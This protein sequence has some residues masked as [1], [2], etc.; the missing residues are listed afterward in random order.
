MSVAFWS[1]LLGILLITM[2]LAGTILARLLLSSAMVYMVVGFAFGPLGLDIVQLDPKQHV[3]VL[4]WGAEL[5]LLISLFAVGLNMG[6]VPLLDKRWRLPLLLAFV[7]MALTVGLVSM[8]GIYLLDLPLGA[9]VLLGGILAPTDPVLASGVQTTL[10]N[11]HDRLRFSLSGE[12]GLN[13]GTAFPFVMLGLGLLGLHDLGVGG[14]RWWLVDLIWATFGGLLIGA[15]S[16]ASIGKLVVYLRT[17]HH[18]AVGRDEFLSLGLI[19][20]AYGAAQLCL[21]SGFLAVFAAGLA[22]QRVKEQPRAGSQS[23]GAASS[24]GGH[25]EG[26]LATHPHHA[27]AAMSHAVQGFNDRLENLAELALVL[28]I[29]VMLA[30]TRPS[31]EVFGLIALLFVPLRAIAVVLGTLGEPLVGHQRNMICWFGIR[32]IG[33][34]FYLMFALHQG[35]SGEQAEQL[36]SLTLLTV[37]AS[38]LLHGASVRP[39]MQWYRRR[40]S[41]GAPPCQ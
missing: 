6:A 2:V 13:D 29:G 4:L 37:A 35:V 24:L 7:S 15:L 38:I 10:N 8:V 25:G 33:S 11:N 14:W 9:A 20:M 12:G 36:V 32:G 19:A 41:E 34:L 23:L 16:G 1:L 26:E 17:R 22:L 27:S 31:L 21:A 3:E 39:L 40:D 30:Y 18:L 5:A 28:L